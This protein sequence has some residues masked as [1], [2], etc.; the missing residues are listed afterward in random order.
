[1]ETE[2]LVREKAKDLLTNDFLEAIQKLSGGDAA[3]IPP[4][5]SSVGHRWSAAFPSPPKSSHEM[6]CFLDIENKFIGTGDY[7]GKLPG[8]VEGAYVS[9]SAA[10]SAL[11][12]AQSK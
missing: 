5:V 2:G 9:G 10:A 11:L 8:R 3:L 12:D 4:I 6:D 7:L 1:M